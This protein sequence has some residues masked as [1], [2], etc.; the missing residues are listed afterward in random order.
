M[1]SMKPVLRLFTIPVVAALL[2]SCA[3]P[4]R[5]AAPA[6]ASR[7][8]SRFTSVGKVTMH[9]GQPCTSQIM[10]DFRTTGVSSTVPLAAPMRETKLLTEAAN[11][12]RRVQIWGTWQ[13][14]QDRT[15]NYVKVIKVQ[16]ASIAIVF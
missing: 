15:C 5:T 12:N 4:A 8:G 7:M 11:R 9:A 1:E 13:R 16:P 10:F 3:Q 14:G 6:R 2:A